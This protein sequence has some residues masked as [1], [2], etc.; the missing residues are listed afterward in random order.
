MFQQ[1]LNGTTEGL[2]WALLALG[3]YIAFRLLD[4]A[5]MTCEGSF[6]LG[7]S[8]FALLTYWGLNPFLATALSFVFGAI[9]GM[10]TGFLH[11]KLKIPPILSGILTMTAL[12]SINLHIMGPIKGALTNPTVT[13]PK[14][15]KIVT[16]L[17][18]IF[19]AVQTRDLTL[20]FTLT[21]VLAMAGFLYWFFGTEI[22]CAIRATGTNEKMC[23][24]QGINTDTTK[25]VGLALANGLI[26][27][28][29]CIFSQYNS[30]A[31]V[32]LGIGS[33]VI[34]LAA[35][36]IG[37]AVFAWA[38]NF[39]LRLCGIVVGAIIYRVI[40]AMIIYFGLPSEDMK[41]FTALIVIVALG[42][43]SCKSQIKAFFARLFAK[44]EKEVDD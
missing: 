41:L 23:R 24:A 22:G 13:I 12:Y 15:D 31:D 30:L 29:G 21:V 18:E 28:S 43:M 8:S 7:G 14:E 34:G 1:L 16:L 32:K 38:K 3:F 9:A 36:I 27:L 2:I 19:P 10:F 25:I 26:A 4:F 20:L 17:K 44:K 35:I 5:D 40:L 6:V 11:T 42:L 33:I 39:F 37:E